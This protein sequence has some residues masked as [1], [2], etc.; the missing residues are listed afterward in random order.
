MRKAIS[1][2]AAVGG[3]A[4]ASLATAGSA[5]A[6]TDAQWDRLAQCE[7]GGNWHI[8]TGNGF[9]GG[10][11][12]TAGTWSAYGGQRYAARADLATR[13]QQIA[14]AS[15]VA[16]GQT[17]NAWPTCSRKAGLR[18]AAPTASGSVVSRASS[19]K[20]SR[21][22]VRRSL[23]SATNTS[24]GGSVGKGKHVVRRGETLSSIASANHIRS[25]RTLYA[26]N[27]CTL[28]NPNVLRIGQVLNLA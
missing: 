16:R 25:W 22:S 18:G 11:Q 6:A 21:S 15:K 23:T 5:N 12:F 14:V 10:L 20:A 17:W 24:K 1:T 3:L 7:S 2:A 19:P 28:K 27:R 8:N 4:V 9:Y 26:A 13:E